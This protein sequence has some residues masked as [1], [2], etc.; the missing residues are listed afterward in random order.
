[1]SRRPDGSSNA[2]SSAANASLF[3]LAFLRVFLGVKFLLAASTK[4]DWIGTP[5]LAKTLSDWA[6]GTPFAWYSHFLT[7]TAIPHAALFTYLVVFGEF[8]VGLLL[9]LGLCTRL[10]ALLAMAL[11][12]NFLLAT[13][14]LG[15]ASQGINEAFLAIAFALLLTGAG[16]AYGLDAR[17]VRKR[18]GWILW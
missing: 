13:W 1:M 2:R 10:G 15:A 4:W 5:Q 3:A 12:A 14:Q 8:G 16:R 17:L 9:T 11:S 7:Q 18:P 6:D